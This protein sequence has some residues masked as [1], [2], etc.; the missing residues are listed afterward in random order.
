MIAIGTAC[1]KDK[2]P[3]DDC[4]IGESTART[5]NN[6]PAAVIESGGKFYIIEQN[7]I[8]T[9]LNPCILDTEFQ[10]H[11]LLVTVSGEVKVTLQDGRWPC[12]T[13]NFVIT[14]ISK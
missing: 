9:R 4:F 6:A 14:K 2:Q 13:E 11:N 12:C 10:I 1:K 8:D 3:G 5:I 7:T